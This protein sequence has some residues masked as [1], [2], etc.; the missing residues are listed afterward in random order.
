MLKTTVFLVSS[1]HYAEVYQEVNNRNLPHY[2]IIHHF[3]SKAEFEQIQGDQNV[4]VRRKFIVQE[5]RKNILNS[6]NYLS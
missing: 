2:G 6:F 4:S 5:T 3:A 1:S